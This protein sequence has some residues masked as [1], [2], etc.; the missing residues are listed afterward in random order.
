M[1]LGLPTEPLTPIY[2]QPAVTKPIKTRGDG[3]P[4]G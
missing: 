2:T 1:E 4:G 3:I